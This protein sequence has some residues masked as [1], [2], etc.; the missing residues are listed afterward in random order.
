MCKITAQECNKSTSG[1]RTLLKN[2]AVQ[3]LYLRGHSYKPFCHCSSLR[4]TRPPSYGDL[5]LS[6]IRSYQAKKDNKDV[7][8][9]ALL[10]VESDTTETNLYFRVRFLERWLSL[11]QDWAKFQARVSSRRTSNSRLQNTVE[12][13]L[14][15]IVMITQNVT[16]SNAQE[17]KIQKRNNIWILD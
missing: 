7:L 11:N 3:T 4:Q 8:F 6:A 1:W 5:F 2:V 9:S 15:D 16:I 17:C 12:P 13:L 10:C 14:R